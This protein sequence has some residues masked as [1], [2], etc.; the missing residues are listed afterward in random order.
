MELQSYGGLLLGS[1][2]KRLSELLYAGVDEVY[3][4]H[5]VTLSSRAFPILFLL[6]DDGPLGVT[7]LAARLGQ[8][9]PA[10]IKMSNKLLAAKLVAA[11]H[12]GADERRRLLAITPKGRAQM[13]RLEPVWRAIVAAVAD[14]TA[15]AGVDLVATVSGCERALLQRDFGARI[16]ERLRAD[17]SDDVE[18]IPFEPRYRD[19]F[20]RLNLEW[21]EKYFQVEPIDHEVLSQPERQILEPGG[22]IFMA[23]HGDEIVGA[24]AL[25]RRPRGRFELSKM[26][27]AERLR[28]RRIGY[29]L[30]QR[31]IAQFVALGAKQLFL[32][33]NRKLASALRLYEANGFCHAPRPKAPSH[34]QRSDVYMVYRPA[35]SA[36]V[37]HSSRAG[38]LAASRTAQ[39]RARRAQREGGRS[40]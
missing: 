39:R 21:L 40:Q 1:R 31:A 7:E 26:V 36:G 8:S 9:H 38:L 32:E 35:G 37:P 15:S 4:A 6:R 18:I 27:V 2:L 3:R 12:D 14:L 34:Y 22:F 33:S 24:C 10:V 30:L 16:G 23:R 13:A 25:I 28:G 20:K 19:D 29:R 17:A 5:G 11:T